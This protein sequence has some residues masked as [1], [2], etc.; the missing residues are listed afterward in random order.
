[1]A[2]HPDYILSQN[3]HLNGTWEIIDDNNVCN[4]S[5]ILDLSPNG[6]RLK[7]FIDSF[8]REFIAQH[9]DVI[10][11]KL[12]TGESITLVNCFYTGGPNDTRDIICNYVV[13]GKKY[14][15]NKSLLFDKIHMEYEEHR[16][17]LDPYSEKINDKLPDKV[18]I[19]KD[20]DKIIFDINVNKNINIKMNYYLRYCLNC[21]KESEFEEHY[22]LS[23]TNKNKFTLKDAITKYRFNWKILLSMFVGKP[24]NI[25]TVLLD[26][27][28]ERFYLY[29]CDFFYPKEKDLATP[30]MYMPYYE[31]KPYLKKIMHYW[32]KRISKQEGY[33][34]ELFFTGFDNLA[35]PDQESFLASIKAIEGIA[36][37]STNN[38]FLNDIQF[39]SLKNIVKDYL[40][41]QNFNSSQRRNLLKKLVIV[42]E[43][44]SLTDK[45][46]RFICSNLPITVRKRLK[47]TD[48]SLQKI[49]KIRNALSHNTGIHYFYV[50]KNFNEF[51][52]I[53]YILNAILFYYYSYKMGIPNEII[54]QGLFDRYFLIRKGLGVK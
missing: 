24:C 20:K 28:K 22:Y 41:Q 38:K 44:K 48:Y 14:L 5:G 51:I 54:S 37:N 15:D 42:N 9:W 39:D 2:K 50:C 21:F 30:W 49:C 36:T 34:R 25:K 17:W 47:L 19:E 18:I 1:M 53:N 32:F 8:K 45:V 16:V 40:V 33:T 43:K 12:L 35:K 29:Y 3:Y 31:V 7:L 23:I 6:I 11:G 10:H 27:S 4:Y 26:K 13:S 46:Q 52:K